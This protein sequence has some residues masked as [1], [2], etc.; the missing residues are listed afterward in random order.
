MGPTLA[1]VQLVTPPAPTLGYGTVAGSIS[2]TATT[3][4]G[5]VGQL[6]TVK[7]CT[8]AGM[9]TGCVTTANVPSGGNATGLTYTQGSPGSSYYATVVAQASPGYLVSGTSAVAGPQAD[10]SLL[11]A[12]GHPHDRPVRD[13]GGRDHRHVLQL[14]GPDRGGLHARRRAPT[15]R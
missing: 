6:Y 8:N 11:N 3:S 1:P 4:N 14:V 2:V 7:A 13:D 10:T 5:P 15:T 9:T 12:A